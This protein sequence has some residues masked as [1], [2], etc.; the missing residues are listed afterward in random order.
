MLRGHPGLIKSQEYT[1]SVF[2]IWWLLIN[3]CHQTIIFYLISPWNVKIVSALFLA[4]SHS[5]VCNLVQKKTKR[6]GGREYYS[7]ICN[8]VLKQQVLQT[9][10]IFTFP[11][12]LDDWSTTNW[13][14]LSLMIWWLIY[15][16]RVIGEVKQRTRGGLFCT[17]IPQPSVIMYSTWRTHMRYLGQV[18]GFSLLTLY[19]KDLKQHCMGNCGTPQPS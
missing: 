18:T 11:L 17:H 5:L 13:K 14:Y 19:D 9:G 2:K 3:L 10:I 8:V 4:L 6:E 1:V 12:V 7:T 15:H 16:A